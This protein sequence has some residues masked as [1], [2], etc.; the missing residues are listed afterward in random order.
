MNDE[1]RTLDGAIN[2]TLSGPVSGQVAIGSGITQTQ[3]KGVAHPEVTSADLAVLQQALA[4]LKAQIEAAA[5]PDSKNAA[6]ARV[7]ELEEAVIARRPDLTTME[8]IKHW[9]TRNLPELAGAVTSIIVHP[10]VGKLVEA[11]G[12]GLADE[13]RHRFGGQ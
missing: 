10:I 5:P 6:L 11:A 3:E 4:S 8:Y 12:N 1:E 9:F 7:A 2:V 13:F